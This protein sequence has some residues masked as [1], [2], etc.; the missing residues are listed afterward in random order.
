[1]N[2]VMDC[3]TPS[4][5]DERPLVVLQAKHDISINRGRT[6]NTIEGHAPSYHAAFFESG[7]ESAI[8][9]ILGIQYVNSYACNTCTVMRR[10]PNCSN[11]MILEMA[12]VDPSITLKEELSLHDLLHANFNESFIISDKL[13]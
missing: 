10:S 1:M 5:K 8:N 3:S 12:L 7:N 4:P 6:F 2:T 13:K 9:D 11:I